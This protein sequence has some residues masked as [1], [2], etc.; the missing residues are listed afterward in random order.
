LDDAAKATL[1]PKKKGK[2]AVVP[3][4]AIEDGAVNSKRHREEKP[5]T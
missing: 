4:E 3:H 2:A 1:L 5:P